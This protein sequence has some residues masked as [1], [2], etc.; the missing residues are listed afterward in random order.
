M[1]IV[2]FFANLVLLDD[3]KSTKTVFKI[4]KVILIVLISNILWKE[5]LNGEIVLP[6]NKDSYFTA[7]WE[8]IFSGQIII[9][10]IL[11]SSVLIIIYFLEK[12][13]LP[14]LIYLLCSFIVWRIKAA[15]KGLSKKFSRELKFILAFGVKIGFIKIERNRIKKGFFYKLY[16][17]YI[18]EFDINEVET[19]HIK[20]FTIFL[21][22]M[23]IWWFLIMNIDALQFK[24]FLNVVFYALIVILIYIPL[25]ASTHKSIN[26]YKD[27]FTGLDAI[28]KLK[29]PNMPNDN[30]NNTNS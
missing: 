9:P 14:I 23:L 13:I 17:V 5:L 26:A 19:E 20:A 1:E 24:P 28:T 10:I 2:E 18:D 29:Q 27:L 12:M 22:I 8:F 3:T 16:R 4:M 7:F 21:E 6:S 15:L 11:I 25:N 30:N